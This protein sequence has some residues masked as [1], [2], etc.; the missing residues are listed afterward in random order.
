MSRYEC[1]SLE[2]R[3][4]I[5]AAPKI[6]TPKL[7]LARARDAPRRRP[8]GTARR[9]CC[10][11]SRPWRCK[12]CRELRGLR[13][14]IP[15]PGLGE[16]SGPGR[17]GNRLLDPAVTLLGD[18]ISARPPHSFT[19]PSWRKLPAVVLCRVSPAAAGQELSGAHG[20]WSCFPGQPKGR[21]WR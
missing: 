14:S 13:A 12:N 7:S 9:T 3:P 1:Y 5:W 6:Q 10:F 11:S 16:R 4:W 19:R 15:L 8:R 17:Q 18:A 20:R 2:C 21:G